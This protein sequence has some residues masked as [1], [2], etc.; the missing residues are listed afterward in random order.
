MRRYRQLYANHQG[1]LVAEASQHPRNRDAARKTVII[2]RQELPQEVECSCDH[3]FAEDWQCQPRLSCPLPDAIQDGPQRVATNLN[4]SNGQCNK[5]HW[6][7]EPTMPELDQIQMTA[8]RSYG[9]RC[10]FCDHYGWIEQS[11][12]DQ[13]RNVLRARLHCEEGGQMVSGWS[14]D[15]LISLARNIENYGRLSDQAGM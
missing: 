12:S 1:R 2:E 6:C 15:K 5:C 14:A 3:G 11:C 8:C 10:A 13:G 9:C 4:H 7:Q